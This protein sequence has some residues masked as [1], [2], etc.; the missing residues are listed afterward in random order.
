MPIVEFTHRLEDILE[1]DINPHLAD[2]LG[3]TLSAAA[4]CLETL[5]DHLQENKPLPAEYAPLLAEMDRWEQ[6]LQSQSALLPTEATLSTEDEISKLLPDL[7]L[8]LPDFI[9][10]TGQEEEPD[11]T[12]DE[13]A[14][15]GRNPSAYLNVPMET[16]QALLNLTG[17]LITSSSQIAEY[18]QHTLQVG[19]QLQQ[20]DERVR[21][22]LDELGEA[23]NQQA[24][25]HP[26]QTSTSDFDQLELE[27]YNDLHSASGLLTESIADNREIA[28]NIQ[29]QL[30]RIA[31]QVYQQQRLQRQLSETILRTRLVPVQSIVAR[32]ER[33]VRE[34]CRRTGKQASISILGQNLQIDTGILQNLTAPLLHLLRNAV[35]H[36][37]ESPEAR[38]A[39]GKPEEGHI[40]L[41]FEQKGNQIHMTLSDDG[42]GMDLERIRSRA[43]ERGLIQPEKTLS[44]AEV[45]RLILLP[46]FTTRDQISD[47]SGRGVGMDVVQSAVENL[48]G[49]LHLNSNPGQG[50]NIHIQVPLALIATHALFVRTGGNLVAIPSGTIQ[51]ILHVTSSENILENGQWSISYQGKQLPVLSLAQVLGWQSDLPDLQKNHSLLIVESENKAYPLH[52]DEVLQP[53]DIVIKN[54]SPWLNLSQGISGACIL[55]DGAVAPVLD[56]LRLLRNLEQ[57]QIQPKAFTPNAEQITTELPH[58]LVVDDSLINRKSLNLMLEQMG[59]NVITAVDGL[60]ALQHLHKESI[61]LILTD[62]EMPRMNGLEMTQAIRIWPEKRHLPILMITSRSTQKHREMAQKAGVD[63]YLTKPVD[64]DTLSTQLQKWLGLRLAA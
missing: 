35:D 1:L 32:V 6:R 50:S 56:T 39:T 2:G 54:L 38:Q 60:D 7:P 45:Y 33:T 26:L 37:I 16:I 62:L 25:G 14:D 18:A 64:R 61:G 42:Q 8:N 48:Q 55:A 19:K 22:M 30:R 31:D 9:R 12:Q 13:T 10:Q 17:E 4:D 46:G 40:Q 53:R 41:N 59:Y 21:Q 49:T 34:T 58:I 5:F 28:R 36:G 52:I 47:I 24:S 44:D 27:A 11:I 29:Q 15:T 20:Q 63:E 23:I 43:L 57:G 3:E 51:Q